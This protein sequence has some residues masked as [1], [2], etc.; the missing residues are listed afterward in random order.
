MKEYKVIAFTGMMCSIILSNLSKGDITMSIL[1]T[2]LSVV[3][4][5]FYL[6]L[7]FKK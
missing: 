4:F 6:Y 5:A 2:A 3:W 1:W 7:T